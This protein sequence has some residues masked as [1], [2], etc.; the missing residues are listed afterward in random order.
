VDRGRHEKSSAASSV[1]SITLLI[2]AGDVIS[3]SGT[4]APWAP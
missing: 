4:A 1:C 3:G 2:A